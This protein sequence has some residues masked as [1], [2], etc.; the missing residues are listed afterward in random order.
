[1]L[2]GRL[3]LLA[4]AFREFGGVYFFEDWNPRAMELSEVK[5]GVGPAGTDY[6][7]ELLLA[8]IV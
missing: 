4:L 3:N 7:C 2:N 8:I 6:L 5:H 1:M